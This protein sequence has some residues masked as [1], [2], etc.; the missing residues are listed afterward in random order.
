MPPVERTIE[1]SAPVRTPERRALKECVVE[2]PRKG[3]WLQLVPPRDIEWNVA[4]LPVNG[5]PQALEAVKIVHLTDLHL[6]RAWLK[7]YEVL[8]EQLERA[9][10]D[11]LL[12]TGDFVD[13]KHNHAPPP[14]PP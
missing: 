13:S 5:L 3:A 1:I 8:L 10:P 7:G 11:L 6:K 9:H 12:V 4:R 2:R 14:P